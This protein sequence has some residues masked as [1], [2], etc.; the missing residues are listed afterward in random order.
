[1]GKRE[2]TFLSGIKK[3]TPS[4]RGKEMSEEEAKR[5]GVLVWVKVNE[6]KNPKKSANDGKRE[7]KYL[8][9]FQGKGTPHQFRKCNVWGKKGTEC[10]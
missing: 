5:W 1:L 4:G 2:S 7:R 10:Q 8:Q 6:G 3:G 9:V